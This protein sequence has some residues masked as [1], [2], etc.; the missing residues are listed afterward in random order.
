[1]KRVIIVVVILV[2]IG[3]G[4][5]FG[6]NRAKEPS[7]SRPA[8]LVLSQ[9]PTTDSIQ[10]KYKPGDPNNRQSGFRIVNLTNNNQSQKSATQYKGTIPLNQLFTMILSQVR[11]SQFTNPAQTESSQV[12]VRLDPALE[13]K[14]YE[15]DLTYSND[16]PRENVL[17]K[18]VDELNLTYTNNESITSGYRISWKDQQLQFPRTMEPIRTIK[19]ATFD[20]ATNTQTPI[21]YSDFESIDVPAMMQGWGDGASYGSEEEAVQILKEKKGIEIKPIKLNITELEVKPK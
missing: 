3:I 7:K 15:V 13:N 5:Y 9:V 11:M 20:P 6:Y 17:N 8:A 19:L 21:N 4:F 16:E 14:Y 12:K 18:V 10:F 1:M 2:V